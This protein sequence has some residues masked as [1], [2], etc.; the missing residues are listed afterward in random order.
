MTD[1]IDVFVFLYNGLKYID[2][3]REEIDSQ[4]CSK[5][6]ILTYYVTDTN[7][8]SIEKLSNSNENFVVVKREDFSHSLTRKQALMSSN[9]DVA[10]LITQD[11]RLVNSDVIEVLS[12]CI[13]DEIKFAYIRQVNTNKT[14]ERYTRRINYPEQSII[15][16][17][18]LIDK[19]GIN[20]F[21]AS[22]ACAAYD[23]N[24]F[25]EVGGYG[26]DL[27]TNE[28]MYYAHKVIMNGYKVKY[29]AD[30][31]V[32]HTHKF[33]L[34]QIEERYYLIG[35]F[36]KENPEFKKYHATN[37]GLKLALKTFGMMLIEFNFY[38]LFTF[39]PNMLARYKG[40]KEG[41]KD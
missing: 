4:I 5:K 18:S 10:V 9:S 27:P 28:D 1:T 12:K 36:F 21:F 23:V 35:V 25:K 3:I 13:D 29:C 15:K 16:D 40:K 30:T 38:A 32:N 20:T 31:F 7:D 39:I 33:T 41:E 17:K 34:K 14:I 8:G 37:S 6:I 2:K 11:C 26:K 22:D 19:M 24:Y